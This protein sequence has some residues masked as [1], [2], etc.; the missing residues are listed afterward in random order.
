MPS[1]SARLLRASVTVG[2]RGENIWD[3]WHAF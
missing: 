2:T 1:Q 3:L